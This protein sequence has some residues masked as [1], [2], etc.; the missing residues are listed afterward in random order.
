MYR[1]HTV[2]QNEGG[3][4]A[5]RLQLIIGIFGRGI[6]Q[7]ERSDAARMI[8]RGR[9]RDHP[10]HRDAADMHLFDVQ[11]IQQ[12]DNI[13]RHHLKRVRPRRL[14]ALAMTTGIVA[15]NAKPLERRQV[16]VPISVI[17]GKAM[18]ETNHRRIR[19][20]RSTHSST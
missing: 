11:R 17:A 1:L 12:T 15:Q 5:P 9:L 14:S 19:R 3:T 6:D 7:G 16:R 4:I 8:E 2:A 20:A 18:I 13:P 10:A